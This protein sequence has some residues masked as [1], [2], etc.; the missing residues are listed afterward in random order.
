M[1]KSKTVNPLSPLALYNL[2]SAAGWAYILYTVVAWY[3]VLG[4]PEYY[5]RTKDIVILIQCG[6]VIEVFNS[7][8]GIV[9][10]P[11]VT[12]SAQVLSRLLVV[13]GIFRLLPETP[14]TGSIA[15]V[16]LLSAWSIT[17]VVRYIFY[18]FT[19]SFKSGPPTILLFLRYNL[20]LILYPTGVA[21]EL[22]LIY[23]SL[24]VAEQKYSVYAKYCLIFS[25]LTYLPGLP[26]LFSHMVVQ[27]RKVMKS[28]REG[29][30]SQKKD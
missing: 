5:L 2:V 20:F 8:L 11:I 14:A 15:Y 6:A 30:T 26:M 9:R 28:L 25:M 3:P 19:L 10:S 21:S 22:T 29:K 27:R 7:A 1:S 17:E 24:S 16:T 18:F 13:I 23:S 4:Q 12:T